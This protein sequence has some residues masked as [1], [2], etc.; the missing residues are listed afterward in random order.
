M[1]YMVYIRNN[2]SGE[3]RL[4]RSWMGD[5]P[6]MQWEDGDDFLWSDG[7]YGCDCNRA[8]F[9]GRAA[10]GG[11]FDAECGCGDFRYSV[12]ITDLAGALLYEDDDWNRGRGR[13][14]A[15]SE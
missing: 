12:R 13:L 3:V 8:H 11:D 2:V 9:F 5:E 6:H 15:E 7:N 4:N 14:M 10:E 1:G